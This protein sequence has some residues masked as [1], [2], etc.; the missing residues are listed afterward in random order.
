MNNQEL[1]K[2]FFEMADYLEIDG[3]SFKPYAY[4]KVALALDSLKRRCWRN[5]QKWRVKS[6]ARNFR[7]WARSCQSY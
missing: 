4:R 7:S 5:L 6:F 2:I 3:V 1:S